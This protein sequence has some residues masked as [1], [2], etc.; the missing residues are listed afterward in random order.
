MNHNTKYNNSGFNISFFKRLKLAVSDKYF[1]NIIMSEKFSKALVFYLKLTL[2]LT[3]ILA[4]INFIQ[5]NAITEEIAIILENELPNFH[6]DQ[7]KLQVDGEMPIEL[8][9]NDI[10]FIIDTTGQTNINQLKPTTTSKQI[11]LITSEGIDLYD[12]KGETSPLGDNISFDMLNEITITKAEIVDNLKNSNL[13]PILLT[14][15]TLFG[16]VFHK[17]IS[18]VYL[19]LAAKI[20]SIIRK[21]PLK[22]L[23]LLAVVLYSLIFP[24]ILHLIISAI[25]V[26]PP[27]FDLISAALGVFFLVRYFNHLQASIEVDINKPRN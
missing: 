14:F 18:P 20:I 5:L 22:G 9:E 17:M 7:G 2:I 26:V 4:I 1:G 25:G 3:A 15:T 8:V 27:F 6:F 24:N 13:V 12:P 10:R 21:I 16:F 11:A 19:F 23:N